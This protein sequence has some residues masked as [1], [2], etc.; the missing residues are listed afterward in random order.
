MERKTLYKGGG[1]GKGGVVSREI[2]KNTSVLGMEEYSCDYRE[3]VS[4]CSTFHAL[5][6]KSNNF[7]F[8]SMEFVNLAA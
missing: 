1:E 8:Q 5:Y 6:M 4:R 2:N 3:N 7:G